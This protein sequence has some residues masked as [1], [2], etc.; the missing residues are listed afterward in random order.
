MED[1]EFNN[2]LEMDSDSDTN[3]DSKEDDIT[4]SSCSELFS[5]KTESISRLNSL[6]EKSFAEDKKVI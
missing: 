3:D 2:S 5:V 6:C 4:C 1:D